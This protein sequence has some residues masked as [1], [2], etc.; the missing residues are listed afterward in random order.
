MANQIKISVLIADKYKMAKGLNAGKYVHG[1]YQID[2]STCT[3][4]DAELFLQSGSTVLE[5]ITKEG[6]G[7]SGSGSRKK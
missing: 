7:G 1:N 5:K 6:S 2:T 3:A 4:A